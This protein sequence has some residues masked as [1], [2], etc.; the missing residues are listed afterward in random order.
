MTS[1]TV[2]GD[3]TLASP[4]AEQVKE[5]FW[6]K[7]RRFASR[8][9]FAEDAVA[10]YYCAF[11][12]SVPFQVRATLLGALAYFLLPVDAFPD[13]MPMLGFADD[14]SVLAAAIA[15]VGAHIGERHRLAARLALAKAGGRNNPET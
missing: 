12:A 8:L 3:E 2:E 7:L 15:A 9:P 4:S 5:R 11:D 1:R 6:P 13:L 14:A 10:A